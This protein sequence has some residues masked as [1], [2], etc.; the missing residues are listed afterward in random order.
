MMHSD[1]L[2][3]LRLLHTSM[4]TC[5][6]RDSAICIRHVHAE[7]HGGSVLFLHPDIFCA[8]P[9]RAGWEA[10]D[11]ETRITLMKPLVL[12]IELYTRRSLIEPSEGILL[13]AR[14]ADC[15]IRHISE[16]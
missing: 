9:Q 7:Y 14:L 5:R 15:R 10:A 3:A 13:P 6:L 12:L 2:D 8:K 16:P 11:P 1:I 4:H